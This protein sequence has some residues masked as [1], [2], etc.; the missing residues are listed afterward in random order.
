VKRI[1]VSLFVTSV[2]ICYAS[3]ANAQVTDTDISVHTGKIDPACTIEGTSASLIYKAESPNRI[4]SDANTVGTFK[5]ICNS[6][7]KLDVKILSATGP[8]ITQTD[9][10]IKKFR[11][12]PPSGYSTITTNGQY[13][14]GPVQFTALAPTAG[15]VVG[16][17]AEGSVANG[18]LPGST[19]N[20]VITVEATIT[21]Q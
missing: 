19:I 7:H 8:A 17:E 18:F 2:A 3:A 11:L 9:A 21:A 1:L 4:S 6:T 13:V 10:Y 20:Y 12:T 5:A 15:Y 16:V 14:V